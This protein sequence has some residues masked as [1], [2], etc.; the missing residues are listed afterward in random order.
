MT[1]LGRTLSD[2][3]RTLESSAGFEDRE[4][5][6]LELLCR[7]VPYEWCALYHAAPGREPRLRVVPTAPSDVVASISESIV[8]LHGLLVDARAHSREGQAPRLGTALAVPLVGDDRVIGVLLVRGKSPDGTAGGYGEQHLRDL[9]V[10]GALLT[11][12]LVM[13]AQARARRRSARGRGGEPFEERVP[14]SR[15]A[16]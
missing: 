9:S 14:G 10:V 2:I 7:L 5:R 4:V 15:F 6:V 13:V 8:T 11:G 12:Y 1:D 3:A 16:R